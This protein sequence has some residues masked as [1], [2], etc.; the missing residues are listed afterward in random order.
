MLRSTAV[1]FEHF[2]L[3]KVK[4]ATKNEPPQFLATQQTL[5]KTVETQGGVWWSQSLKIGKSEGFKGGRLIG[6]T[7]KQLFAR[8]SWRTNLL[9]CSKDMRF[10]LLEQQSLVRAS[11]LQFFIVI[12]MSWSQRF[13]WDA[14]NPGAGW[15]FKTTWP[16]R[17]MV[18]QNGNL[19]SK[20]STNQNLASSELTTMLPSTKGQ[21]ECLASMS[22]LQPWTHAPV[23]QT[24]SRLLPS[25][26][27]ARS[28][29]MDRVF[30]SVVARNCLSATSFLMT[31]ASS[32][33][34]KLWLLT[35]EDGAG[36]RMT[37]FIAA[38]GALK[39]TSATARALASVSRRAIACLPVGW[40][41]V[42]AAIASA[43][44]SVINVWESSTLDLGCFGGVNAMQAGSAERPH[45]QWKSIKCLT[46]PSISHQKERELHR[47]LLNRK[48]EKM[49]R[50]LG[51]DPWNLWWRLLSKIWQQMKCH[52][53]L[54][55]VQ[56]IGAA[57]AQSH[58]KWAMNAPFAACAW[59]GS[60]GDGT[61]VIRS[62]AA[63]AW[64]FHFPLDAQNQ[65]KIA[66]TP[67]QGE[68]TIQRVEAAFPLWFK[69]KKSLKLLNEE[70]RT[71]HREMASRVK[72]LSS[73]GLRLSCRLNSS[74]NKTQQTFQPGD[75]VLVR[76]QATF[77]ATQWKPAKLTLKARG[78]HR[79]LERAGKRCC[80]IQK[81]PVIQSLTK[82]AGKRM[83]EPAMQMEKTPSSMVTHRQVATCNTGL[84]EME[85]ELVSNPLERNLGFCCFGKFTTAPNNAKRAFMTINDMWNEEAQAE[86]SSDDE[87]D[88]A[89][90]DSSV[91]TNV[92]K[93]KP[94]ANKT[95][96]ETDANKTKPKTDVDKTKQNKTIRNERE[97]KENKTDEILMPE[98]RLKMNPQLSNK[99][100]PKPFL[101]ELWEN[102]GD[103]VEK[104]FV[105]FKRQDKPNKPAGSKNAKTLTSTSKSSTES[106]HR[107][108]RTTMLRHA[109]TSNTSSNALPRHNKMNATTA[110]TTNACKLRTDKLKHQL[111]TLLCWHSNAA[112]GFSSDCNVSK[113]VE[114]RVLKQLNAWDC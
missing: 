2:D 48:A 8:T 70:R 7:S 47:M 102:V 112:F 59:N 92:S 36:G 89:D 28:S 97:R 73:P 94:K 63:K 90:T 58:E 49:D 113:A 23:L 77:N 106:L 55:K 88:V 26:D 38:L 78:P 41:R 37:V 29:Q 60:P 101:K 9:W 53:C 109:Q 98:K 22:W 114:W 5:W 17:H 66:M 54:N 61:N 57:D 76:K 39:R 95:K 40:L 79:I 21:H 69:Q 33:L 91:D 11:H 56:Q 110:D 19:N 104:L 52:Q 85:G 10:E 32:W 84:T 96:P 67:E 86:L 99:E 25:H 3:P 87:A 44:G 107:F 68:A 1:P 14:V 6:K 108:E 35:E 4:K 100:A 13:W 72:P 24:P 83:K 18:G 16:L 65:D 81:L 80:W 50:W 111:L 34:D 42:D 12:D 105:V 51:S 15:R 43:F 30:M 20:S 75:L 46:W 71:K 93:T 103:S 27:V 64:T 45:K 62:F 31:S 82:R 74:H